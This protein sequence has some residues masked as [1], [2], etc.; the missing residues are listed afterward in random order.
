MAI[1]SLGVN[2]QNEAGQISL[3]PM[4]GINAAT[5]TDW[6]ETS[7]KI[8]FVGGVEAEYGFSEKFSLSA[9]L[10]YSMQGTKLDVVEDV[11]TKV[12]T[13][14]L[15]IPVLAN[16]YVWKGLAVKA[17]IQ[18]GILLSAKTKS[19]AEGNSAEA[20]LKDNCESLDISIPVGVS[21]EI[22]NFVIDARY[23]FGLTNLAKGDGE[24]NPKNSVFSL[25]V[26]YK[27]KL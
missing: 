8:G 21:Y 24:G 2:A 1:A 17:G 11:D 23:N 15:N 14:Y 25:T 5:L 27:F 18:P 12:N 10:L 16:F 13:S 7:M 3:K 6:D 19:E 20:D 4:A 9:G 26:G 22:S